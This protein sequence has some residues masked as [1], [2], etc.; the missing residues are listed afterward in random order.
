MTQHSTIRSTLGARVALVAALGSLLASCDDTGINQP[1]PIPGDFGLRLETV[2]SGLSNPVHLTAAP[3]DDRL[4]VT[5]QSGRIIT[6]RDGA[7]QADPFLDLRDRVSA[8]GER[9]LLSVAFHPGYRSNGYFFVNYTDR[10]GNT[11]VERFTVTG[12]GVADPSSGRTVLTVD[13]PFSNHNGGLLRFGPDGYLYIGMGD[14]G[15]G[16]D[17]LGNGQN[18]E[19]LLGAML[20]IDVD[21]LPYTIPPDNPLRDRAGARPEIW[22]S[23]LRN[24]WRF[25]FDAPQGTLYIADVG[26]NRLEEINAVPASQGG[27]NYGWNIM[28]GST[29]FAPGSGCD[30]SGLTLPVAEYD[31]GSGCSV[32]G[33]HVYRG[34]TIPEILGH[35]FY[36]DYCSG[37]LWSFRLSN[38]ET[39]EEREWLQGIGNVTSF[40]VDN[41][42]ELYILVAAG[43]VYRIARGSDS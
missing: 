18:P 10:R 36:S 28:E 38:G 24:P 2:A 35:Y 33:G 4:F 29:C 40:G 39:T 42:G 13:Q 7:V 21:V 32:T 19:T 17:P 5:E 30:R 3:G 22:A 1:E 34:A 37:R 12:S 8:G 23:G 11:V 31:H 15:S 27:L 41:Q 14:G 6:I 9:G 43:T 25:S 26:Q 16:G 20:R